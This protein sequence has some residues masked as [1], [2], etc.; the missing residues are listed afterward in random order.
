MPT[1]WRRSLRITRRVC[2]YGALVLLVLAALLVSIANL[3][4]PFVENN[5]QR[6]KQWLSEQVGKPVDFETSQTQW[7]RRGPKIS[8]TGLHVGE[9][10]GMVRIGR[11]ELLVSIYSGLLPNHPFTELKIKGLLL[12][13]NQQQDDSWQL[14]GVPRQANSKADPLEVLSGFGELQ[15]ENTVLQVMPKDKAAFRIPRID[16]RMRVQGSKLSVGL[17]AEAKPG[18]L[19]LFLVAKLSREDYSGKI[20]LGAPKLNLANWTEIAP[21]LNLPKL[22]AQLQADVWLDVRARKIMRL[23]SQLG[24]KQ[25]SF[26][27]P[28]EVKIFSFSNTPALF[29][30]IAFDTYWRRSRNGWQFTIPEI[31]FSARNVKQNITGIRVQSERHIWRGQAEAVDIQ[32]LA[33]LNPAASTYLPAVQRFLRNARLKGELT[34][35]KA[36]GSTLNKQWSINGFADEVSMSAIRKY[37]GF[38]H[39]SGTF[40][41]D[42]SGGSFKFRPSAASLDW[43]ISFGRNIPST[44]NGS[45]LWWKS[46]DDWV[47]AAK[48]LRWQGDGM[49]ADIDMQ[50]QFYADKRKPMLNVAARLAS[51][52]FTTAKRFWLR[53]I[54]TPN[55]MEWLDMAL[56]KGRALNPSIV[57]AGDLEHWPFA[58]KH[59]RFSAKTTIEAKQFKFLKDWPAADNALLNADFNG[60]GFS[61]TGKADYM[62]NALTLGPSGIAR[63]KEAKLLLDIDAESSMQ[64]L[65]PVVNGTPLK[66]TLG[67]SVYSL[68][69]EG[70]VAVHVG[71]QF[72]LKA[73]NHEKEIDGSID[74]KG[75]VIRAPLWKLAMQQAKGKAS[76]TQQGFYA[77][78]LSG[79]IDGN[80]VKLDLRVGKAYTQNTNNHFEAAIRGNFEAE[81]L[82]NFDPSLHDLKKALQGKSPW[83]FTVSAP[84]SKNQSASPVF[85]RAQSEM[86]GTKIILPEPLHKPAAAAQSFNL[87]TQLPVDKGTIDLKLGSQFRLLLKKPLN[88]PMSG[89]AL[90]GSQTQAAIPSTGFSVRGQTE[91]FDVASWMALSN[92]AEG[93]AGL[94]SFDLIVNRLGLAGQEFGSTRLLMNP[95]PGGTSIRAQGMSLD[96]QVYL[97]KAKNTLITANFKTVHVLPAEKITATA[98]LPAS[99]AIDFGSP[100]DLPPVSLLIQDLRIVDV[101]LGR[102]E[103]Q[104]VPSAQGLLI[105]KFNTQSKLMALTA[106]GLWHGQKNQARTSLQATL[107][108]KDLGRL[109]TAF[110]YQDVIKSGNAKAQFTGAWAGS[111]LDFSL[112]SFNGNLSLDVEKGQLLGVEPGGGRVLG[113]ISLA[114]IPRRLSFNFSD[115]FDKGFG[116]NQIK[117]QF[118]FSQ[119]KASTQD[120]NIQA[121]AADIKITGSTDLVKQEFN[122]YVEV[123][124]KTSGLLPVIGAVAGGPI[125]A[126]AGVMA[127]AVL[128]KPLK[129]SAAAYYVIT[130]PW[131]KPEVKKLDAKPRK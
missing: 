89:I 67:E 21:S 48:D 119:G 121:P 5:P 111:P 40:V 52:D 14:Y 95:V 59:G 100:A 16:M 18:D 55:L 127:Q 3:C 50:L 43:P 70:P 49:Q 103:I 69:G 126:A 102:C 32:P 9:G 51:F 68:Q 105:Q 117:G 29:D 30:T 108:S 13:F 27:K 34:K 130:G 20:W 64:A 114:E 63:F 60:P 101:D 47:L 104:T 31:R 92:K 1:S 113:L 28:A 87:L 26:D 123:R 109:L 82:L 107:T 90:F 66:Q 8:L 77:K 45:V 58:D 129:D 15:L 118:F 115:F 42:Q 2:A 81:Y 38:Q 57:I 61:V 86:V 98:D 124:A 54:M 7:T 80:P 72:P 4:L 46:S 6:V 91:R 39:V 44:F 53:H 78:E 131:A 41:A 24:F 84:V 110:H 112:K 96:G 76:F 83:L 23:H 37:P 62:G 74:F 125:G 88:K 116:F 17:R 25:V 12:R 85:L 97:P 22:H 99:M 128:D 75:L 93:G 120:L 11:A 79:L 71:M 33:A 122:Q 65:M 36:N 10:D 56:V 19:P 106:T 73:V 35:L 94:Q